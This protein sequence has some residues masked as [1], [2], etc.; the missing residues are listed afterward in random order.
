MV[1]YTNGPLAVPS[2]TKFPHITASDLPGPTKVDTPFAGGT[3]RWLDRHEKRGE[4]W[5]PATGRGQ[6]VLLAGDR[7]LS[8]AVQPDP[9]D[10]L[11]VGIQL[12]RV[13][14]NPRF[15]PRVTHFKP[16]SI[17]LCQT[18]ILPLTGRGGGGVGCTH[19]KPWFRKG[20][21]LSMSGYGPDQIT[22]WTGL[23]ADEVGA[24]NVF[25]ASGRVIPAALRDNA[26]FF[27]APTSQLPAKIVAYDH[28]RRPIWIS[29]MGG[30]PRPTPCP[31]ARPAPE[32]RPA[33]YERV[34]L[35]ARTINGHRL[36]GESPARIRAALGKPDYVRHFSVSNGHREPT[37][38]YG[39]K[40]PIPPAR[41]PFIT[42]RTA[43]L[44]VRFGWR[45]HRIRALSFAYRD[46][47]VVDARLKSLLRLQPEQLER[48]MR[49]AYR[50]EYELETGY[51]SIP[52][53]VGCTAVF[54]GRD[55]SI[56]LSFG[57]DPRAGGVP[58]LIFSHGY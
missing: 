47:N 25:L 12:I 18:E 32:T 57:I 34:D 7:L 23:A 54:V 2:Y 42:E 24:I 5:Q 50:S 29:V 16:G 43:D 14:S 35:A 53:F 4:P 21:P 40:H 41:R 58:F 8:R 26:F 36:F 51:G 1:D 10:P 56:R 55:T 49:S 30:A 45:Q 6:T 27:S 19:G 11:R 15:P 39:L 3:I 44:A 22:Q 48:R 9:A 33:P 28:E 46:A 52:A 13:G 20:Q 17:A 31:P 37:Y 38:F